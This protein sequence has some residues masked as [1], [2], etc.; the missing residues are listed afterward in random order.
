VVGHYHQIAKGILEN[1]SPLIVIVATALL[2]SSCDLY[3][4]LTD[5]AYALRGTWLL[6]HSRTS[7]DE[8]SYYEFIVSADNTYEIIGFSSLTIER[9]VLSK[10][11]S[12]SFENTISVQTLYPN[13][14]G[15]T[16][17]AKWAVSNSVLTVSFYSDA[18]MNTRYITFVCTRP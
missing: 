3:N 4:S 13:I 15:N 16:P 12:T 14:V 7:P 5:P 17:Y 6:D 11:T 8:P 1:A 18:T 2:F 9:G 10:V